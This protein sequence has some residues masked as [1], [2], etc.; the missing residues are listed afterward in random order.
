MAEHMHSQHAPSVQNQTADPKPAC[1]PATLGN[2]DVEFEILDLGSA[3]LDVAKALAA[4]RNIGSCSECLLPPEILS[5][6]SADKRLK[7]LQNHLARLKERLSEFASALS[8]ASHRAPSSP[9]STL[10]DRLPNSPDSTLQDR[11][12]S[13]SVADSHLPTSVPCHVTAC[14]TNYRSDNFLLHFLEMSSASF[15]DRS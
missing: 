9:D 1:V 13:R 12:A 6:L 8:P 11:D 7:L 10:W 3:I 14:G 15:P 4:K 5:S 2:V